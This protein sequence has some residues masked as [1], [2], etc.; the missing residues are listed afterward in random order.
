MFA[1][2]LPDTWQGRREAEHA[3]VLIRFPA[4]S[5]RLVVHVLAPAG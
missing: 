4:S 2:R 3:I 5:P 1:D